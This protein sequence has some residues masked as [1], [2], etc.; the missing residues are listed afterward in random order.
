M[1]CPVCNEEIGKFIC[2][3]ST[4]KEKGMCFEC[5]IWSE[6][7]AEF[8]T[9]PSHQV[10][11]IDGTYY[12]IGDESDPSSFRG[13]GG[14]RFQIEF[15]DSYKVITTNLWC[16]GEISSKYWRDRLPNNARFENNLK[17]K[18]I[19]ECSYLVED[20]EIPDSIIAQ[21]ET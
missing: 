15:N 7:L 11:I 20:K 13:F 2:D 6:R 3:G 8:P 21:I 10:A 14:R 9:L 4:L 12:S 16:G 19:G 1:K 18:K 5:S 17:W